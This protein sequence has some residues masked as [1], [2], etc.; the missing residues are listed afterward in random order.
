MKIVGVGQCSWD[1][2]AV[3]DSF[4]C[5]DSKNEV[6]SWDEQGGGPTATALVTLSRLGAG[7]SFHGIVGDD[8]EAGKIR[9]SLIDEGIDVC[10]LLLRARS[11]S[12]KAFI[13]IERESGK[14]TIF[15]KR[16]TGADLETGEMGENFLEGADFLML[17]GLMGKV[18]LHAAMIAN[19]MKVPVMLDAGSLREGMLDLAQRG[20]YV[21]ASEKFARQLGY[22]GD[23]GRFAALLE[24]LGLL[25]TTVT[26]GEKGSITFMDDRIIT[27][28]AFQV[29]A[30]DTTGAGDV[31]HGGYAYGILNG[32]D[33][34]TVLHFASAMAAMKCRSIGG[35]AGITD[36]AGAVQFMKERGFDLPQPSR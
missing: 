21:V 35:R 27:V 14:R 28:P 12:Q 4:P 30:A 29:E 22:D 25:K 23:N 3:V 36:L 20:D 10:G 15:W 26:M 18:S 32:W 34:E 9:Q 19:E 16:H 33:I 1:Y 17:D 7:C 5:S 24:G 6:L 11:E 2:L 13:V 8:P 31:F